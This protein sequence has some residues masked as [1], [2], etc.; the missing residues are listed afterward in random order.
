MFEIN[1]YDRSMQTASLLALQHFILGYL[2]LQNGRHI[3]SDEEA[4]WLKCTSQTA[5]SHFGADRC[6]EPLIE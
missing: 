5:A 4:I 6:I 2:H 1:F 3:E